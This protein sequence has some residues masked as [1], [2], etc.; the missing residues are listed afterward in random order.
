MT[1]VFRLQ[2]IYTPTERCSPKK[3]ATANA[4]TPKWD[5][6]DGGMKRVRILGETSDVD[7]VKERW[8]GEGETLGSCLA[9]AD[10]FSYRIDDPFG[11]QH[12]VSLQPFAGENPNRFLLIKFVVSRDNEPF[13][14]R[15]GAVVLKEY[16][17][18]VDAELPEVTRPEPA[19]SS[20]LEQYKLP[21]GVKMIE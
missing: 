21:P 2:S 9:D 14:D 3:T 6:G 13:R 7:V 8:G 16:D 10:R 4:F 18:P 1:T 20:L 17:L 12:V 15:P 11:A 19:D 5:S